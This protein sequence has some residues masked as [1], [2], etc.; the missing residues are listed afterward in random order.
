MMSWKVPYEIWS[1]QGVFGGFY[2]LEIFSTVNPM[3]LLL[4]CMIL[5]ISWGTILR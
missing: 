4:Y 2:C 3:D 1:L 5:E